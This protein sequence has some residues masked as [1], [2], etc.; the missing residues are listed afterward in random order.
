[1]YLSPSCLLSYARQ[2]LCTFGGLHNVRYCN[3]RI[4]QI[5]GES[6]SPCVAKRPRTFANQD[7]LQVVSRQEVSPFSSNLQTRAP[8]SK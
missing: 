8:R 3:W 4:E 6:Q 7:S 2:I 5:G 1:M